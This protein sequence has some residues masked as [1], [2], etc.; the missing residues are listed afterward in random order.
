MANCLTVRSN[1][2]PCAYKNRTLISSSPSETPPCLASLR[3]CVML[4]EISYLV[5]LGQICVK[6]L[7]RGSKIS[8]RTPCKNLTA[9]YQTEASKIEKD[10]ALMNTL[11]PKMSLYIPIALFHFV[12]VTPSL[13]A[14]HSRN[15][16]FQ[17]ASSGLSCRC[18]PEFPIWTSLNITFFDFRHRIATTIKAFQTDSFLGC[19]FALLSKIFYVFRKSLKASNLFHG[20]FMVS[21]SGWQ[22]FFIFNFFTKAFTL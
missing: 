22:G 18:R 3:I 12:C 14:V 11:A 19:K 5:I 4:S 9:T 8:N 7:S 6:V 21:G 10:K 2:S 15:F 1:R 13:R 20:F 16:G 17:T